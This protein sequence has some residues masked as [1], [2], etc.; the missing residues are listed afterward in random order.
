MTTDDIRTVLQE[1][2]AI[3]DRISDDHMFTVEEEF[4]LLG[5]FRLQVFTTAGQ[6]PVAVA[7]QTVDEGSSLM[8]SSERY[9]AAVWERHFPDDAEPPIWVERQILPSGDFDFFQLVTFAYTGRYTLTDPSWSPLTDEQLTQLVGTVV[10]HSRG[11][12]YVPRPAEPEERPCYPTRWLIRFPR[13][14]P[15]REDCMKGGLPLRRRLGRQ[16][17]PRHTARD[18]CW[19]HGGDWH[20]VCEAAI[21]LVRHAQRARIPGNDIAHHVLTQPEAKH[22]SEWERQALYSLLHDPI[23]LSE[24]RRSYVNGQHRAQAMLDVGVHRTIVIT[25][26]QQT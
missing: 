12:G 26:T 6:R 20:H 21:R 18:C 17:I 4:F 19:Y 13:P 16:L 8:N 15:F 3:R 25:W 7:T 2:A 5:T 1:H 9:A 23:H 14:R 24:N 11:D 22:L 10:D